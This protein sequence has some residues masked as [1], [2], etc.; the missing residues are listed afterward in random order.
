MKE[1]S[2]IIACLCWSATKYKYSGI[3]PF[4]FLAKVIIK[5]GSHSGSK[6]SSVSI[7]IG[8]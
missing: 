1:V 4:N 8:I 6:V 7:T 3:S 5:I 2:V